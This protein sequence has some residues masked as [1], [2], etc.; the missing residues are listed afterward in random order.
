MERWER[1]SFWNILSGG[2][3]REF[4]SCFGVDGCVEDREAL[5]FEAGWRLP[6]RKGAHFEGELRHVLLR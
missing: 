5:E 3:R 2:C 1:Y 6:F 4:A